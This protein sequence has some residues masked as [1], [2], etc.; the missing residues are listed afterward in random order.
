MFRR[1]CY[2]K[3]L[4]NAYHKRVSLGD[5]DLDLIHNQ[6]LGVG[7]IHL[8]YGQRV[9]VDREFKIW[10]ARNGNKAEAIPIARVII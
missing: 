7:S 6:R 2:I 5:K 3:L 1:P 9:V 4:V 8:D 10:I